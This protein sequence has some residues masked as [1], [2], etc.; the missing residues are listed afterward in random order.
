[1]L[2]PHPTYP[3]AELLEQIQAVQAAKPQAG[4]DEVLEEVG[5]TFPGPQPS[6]TDTILEWKVRL[7]LATGVDESHPGNWKVRCRVYLRDLQRR[8]GLSESALQHVAR[9]AAGRYDPGT[10]RLTLTSDGYANR[11]DNR[12]EVLR[13][14]DALVAEGHRAYPNGA[15]AAVEDNKHQQPAT[16]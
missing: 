9:V 2:P 6:E 10:G 15:A 8:E 4:I 14:L 16:E 3:G 12:R 1:V 5:L 11:E 7:V 13:A